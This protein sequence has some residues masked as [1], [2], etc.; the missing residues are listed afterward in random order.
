MR[1]LSDFGTTPITSATIAS[2]YPDIRSKSDKIRRL[3]Q[4]GEIIRLKRGLYIINDQRSGILPD[5]FLIANHIYGPSYVSCLT[6][7][8]H[9]GIIPE[10]VSVVQSMTMKPSK[11]FSNQMGSYEYIHA[12]EEYY[13]IGIRREVDESSAYLIATP[14]KALCDLIVTTANLNLRYKN[15]IADY[16]EDDMRMDMEQLMQMDVSILEAC[17]KVSKKKTM[18]NTIIKLIKNGKSI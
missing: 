9:Y 8:R 13:S 1:Y 14:E 11:N 12:D 7:L 6:A 17:A 3:E 15:E 5:K 2:F 16:L 10:R 4:S 18:I